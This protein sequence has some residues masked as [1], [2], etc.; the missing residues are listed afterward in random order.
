MKR[1][2]GLGA[3]LIL[4]MNLSLWVGCGDDDEGTTTPTLTQGDT[5]DPVFL[6]FR[7]GYE[8]VDQFTS[9]MLDITFGVTDSILND[10]SNPNAKAVFIPNG[11]DVE[12]DSS[13]LTYHA[14][15]GYWYLYEGYYDPRDSA[16]VIDSVQFLHGATP[17][18]WP[19]SAQLSGIKSGLSLFWSIEGDV[20]TGSQNMSLTG[21]F[22]NFGMVTA[23]GT[24]QVS[25]AYHDSHVEVVDD[26][27]GCDFDMTF[28]STITNVVFPLGNIEDI[29]PQSGTMVHTATVDVGCVGETDTLDY[30]GGWKVT[31]TFAGATSTW[32]IENTTTRWS[33]TDSCG[34][35]A[36]ANIRLP[37]RMPVFHKADF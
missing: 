32:V 4:L 6:S 14:S 3:A 37:D 25:Y 30:S 31:L 5:L 16:I 17:V 23:N 9:M 26:T 12:A 24:Q 35:S 8:N 33:G 20:V 36:S 10:P 7:D 19:D 18:Q 28:N 34:S 15:S 11:L 2:L 1:I 27:L 13:Y 29:C 21:D 22:P